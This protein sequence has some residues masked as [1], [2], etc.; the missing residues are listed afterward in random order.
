M[1]YRTKILKIFLWFFIFLLIISFDFAKAAEIE[2]PTQFGQEPTKTLPDYVNY[3]YVFAAGS[4]G[5][6]SM[7]MLIMGGI[8]L[9]TASG[10]PDLIFKA[11]R[12]ILGAISGL[13]LILFS[14]TIINFLN[15]DLLRL[16]NP[17]PEKQPSSEDK[18]KKA[19]E[20]AKNY[21]NSGS[22]SQTP[23]DTANISGVFDYGQN[24]DCYKD[25]GENGDEA[26]YLI[27]GADTEE[28]GNGDGNIFFCCTLR[29]TDCDDEGSECNPT[30]EEFCNIAN[31][32]KRIEGDNNC[33]QSEQS[34]YSCAGL[35]AEGI[36]SDCEDTKIYCVE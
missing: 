4:A 26:Q 16:K 18:F 22:S 13:L 8:Q 29:E 15:P 34:P 21:L 30:C 31:N 24:V 7:V 25:P 27:N 20:D 33:D 9:I 12:R 36:K 35:K 28:G 2:Y 19:I 1:N 23:S 5:F 32:C 17:N 6:L 14:Y 11:R 3:I 10:N